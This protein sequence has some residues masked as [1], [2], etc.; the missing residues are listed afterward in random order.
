MLKC[1]STKQTGRYLPNHEATLDAAWVEFKDELFCECCL[2]SRCH[3]EVDFSMSRVDR[4]NCTGRFLSV[5]ISH[6]FQD[7]YNGHPS[8]VAGHAVGPQEV[9][10]DFSSASLLLRWFAA[11]HSRLVL[12]VDRLAERGPLAKWNF[13]VNRRIANLRC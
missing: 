1:R 13:F 2:G 7:C 9:C 4:L 10:K 8:A 3:Q 6:P 12:G 11:S 5:Y